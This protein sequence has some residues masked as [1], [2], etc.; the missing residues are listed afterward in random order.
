M[1][2]YVQ[3]LLSSFYLQLGGVSVKLYII[4]KPN[5]APN[6]VF[7]VLLWIN[8]TGV[9]RSDVL[10]LECKANILTI[11]FASVRYGTIH[12]NLESILFTAI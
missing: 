3:S 7:F 11:V 2:A 5:F 4:D 1:S 12:W 8:H 10:P 9:P 6:L